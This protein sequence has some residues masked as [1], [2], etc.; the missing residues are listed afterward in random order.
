MLRKA[1]GG[2]EPISAGVKDERGKGRVAAEAGGSW[3]ELRKGLG[4]G[5]VNH[6]AIVTLCNRPHDRVRLRLK[7]GDLHGRCKK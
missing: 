1:C 4:L 2:Q 3:E 7:I 6:S 5:V